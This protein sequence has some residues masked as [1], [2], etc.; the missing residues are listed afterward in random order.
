MNAT[1]DCDFAEV[2][3]GVRVEVASR[4][5]GANVIHIFA[6]EEKERVSDSR[7]QRDRQPRKTPPK[8]SGKMS[9]S[10]TPS[11]VPAARL[12]YAQSDL[13]TRCSDVLD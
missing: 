1:R 4:T 9:K 7:C 10:V 12:I 8:L 5:G 13:C 2:S 11:S 3:R 6:D